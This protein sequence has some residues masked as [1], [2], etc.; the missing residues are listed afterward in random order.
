MKL[1]TDQRGLG[2]APSPATVPPLKLRPQASGNTN[3]VT[4]WEG[5]V[6]GG[7]S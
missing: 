3:L 2:R 4:V 1:L 7:L 6:S 5:S